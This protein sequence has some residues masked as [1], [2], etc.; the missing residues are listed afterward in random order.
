MRRDEF[1]HIVAA[2]ANVEDARR[3]LRGHRPMVLVLDA[4]MP[5]GSSLQA[6]LAAPR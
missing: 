6:I 5:G 4:N 1:E 3:Y 2:A